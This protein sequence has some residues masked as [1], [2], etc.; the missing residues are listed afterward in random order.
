MT[1]GQSAF[2]AVKCK[3]EQ[4]KAPPSL[5]VVEP[6]ICS[7]LPYWLRF[8]PRLPG[9]LQNQNMTA[10]Q[11]AFGG[12][13]VCKGEQSKAPPYRGRPAVHRQIDFFSPPLHWAAEADERSHHRFEPVRVTSAANWPSK[14]PVRRASAT[15]SALNQETDTEA[16]FGELGDPNAQFSPALR[17]DDAAFELNGA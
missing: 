17:H 16:Y 2:G 8:T 10:G 3:G 5:P 11:S 6:N 13:E 7:S 15:V 12:R 14:P 4:S 9:T 1:A